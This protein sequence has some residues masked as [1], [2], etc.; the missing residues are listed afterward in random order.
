MSHPLRLTKHHGLGNDFL[1]A[2]SSENSSLDALEDSALGP[3]AVKLCD[4][5]RGVGAD[6]FI[7]GR[8]GQAGA[9]LR[10]VLH[11][12]DGS[13]A[14]ISGNGIRCLAQAWQR[15]TERSLPPGEAAEGQCVIDAGSGVRNLV[16]VHTDDPAVVSVSVEMG[17]VGPGPGLGPAA[18]SIP[19]LHRGTGDIGNPHL[20]VHVES[21]DDIDLAAIGP[22]LEDEVAG[23]VN[24]HFLIVTADDRIELIHWE[25]GAGVTEACG[26]GATVSSALARRWGLV[27]G[28]VVHVDMPGGSADVVETDGEFT[29]RGPAEFIA[30]VMVWVTV[31]SGHIST[32]RGSEFDRVG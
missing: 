13:E 28:P 11:N 4:R 22:V 5:H 31:E 10:M 21:F 27:T 1:V 14:E 20:V 32:H 12:A 29:L 2:L 8:R 26:S 17:R 15:S 16:I 7:V 3:L 6:G 23:G 9:D 19:A 25:R 30:E 18:S 24:V